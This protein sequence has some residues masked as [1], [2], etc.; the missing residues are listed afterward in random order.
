LESLGRIVNAYLDLAEERAKRQIP[1]TMQDWAKRLD[2]FLEYDDRAV[3]QDAGKITTE[4]AKNHAETEFEKSFLRK[5]VKYFSD[6]KVGCVVGNLIYKVEDSPISQSEG[7]YFKFEKKIRELES[8]LGILAT[9]TGA[10]MAV[11]KNLWKDLT[12]IDDSDFTTPLDI[13]LQGYKVVYAPDAIA[14][15]IPPSSVKGELKARIRQTS[16]NLV[17]TLKR[18][19]W[20]GWIKHPFVSWG[21]LSHKILR[22]FTPFFMIGAFISNLFILDKGIFYQL[23]FAGQVIFYLIA[24]FGM[25][26]ELFK[27][28]IPI[29]STIFSFCIAN[30]GMGIGVIK[31]LLGKAPAAFKMEE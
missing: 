5:I 16:K 29:A 9:A 28:R 12:P 3:L 11:R 21:L 14:Y 10:C 18:W 30:I 26:G 27:I 8:K 23:T 7:L 1:M 15:D 4:I 24:V 25:G 31:G 13:I 17:G 22:W 6:K 2:L 19:G 20:R